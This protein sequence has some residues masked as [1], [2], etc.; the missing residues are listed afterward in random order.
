MFGVRK[1]EVFFKA[2]SRQ[3]FR[4]L[5]WH[6][7]YN[8][9]R[10]RNSNKDVQFSLCKITWSKQFKYSLYLY[11]P[12]RKGFLLNSD[13]LRN[14]A[15]VFHLRL[16]VFLKTFWYENISSIAPLSREDAWKAAEFSDILLFSRCKALALF[17]FL[18]CAFTCV[19]QAFPF[20]MWLFSC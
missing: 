10:I 7:M 3:T 18:F 9:R 17:W 11:F 13:I 8:Y 6:V 5:L 19:H 20:K 15:Q 1:L 12:A 4:F 2:L 14:W 16:L